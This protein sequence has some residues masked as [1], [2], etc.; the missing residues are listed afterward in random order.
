MTLQRHLQRR[1]QQCQNNPFHPLQLRQSKGGHLL[2]GHLH[3]GF[4]VPS[5]VLLQH[6]NLHQRHLLSQHRQ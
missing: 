2:L 6:H 3:R 1:Q 4:R 5:L